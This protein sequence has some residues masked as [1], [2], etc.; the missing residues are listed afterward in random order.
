MHV[1]FS[2]V[3]DAQNSLEQQWAFLFHE[4]KLTFSTGSAVGLHKT[5]TTAI[6]G[7]GI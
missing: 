3:A 7:S 6:A 2:L 5:A 1:L 4:C